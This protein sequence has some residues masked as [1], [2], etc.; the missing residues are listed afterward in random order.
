MFYN[1]LKN[2]ILLS[3]FVFLA[4][5]TVISA[6]EEEATSFKIKQQVTGLVA[7][8]IRPATDGEEWKNTVD[9]LLELGTYGQ[10]KLAG[11]LL[12]LYK[13]NDRLY[14]SSFERSSVN[15][16]F[17][18]LTFWWLSLTTFLFCK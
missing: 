8:L 2:R 3:L 9:E 5:I 12:G 4:Y 6:Q 17:N 16:S 1:N 13:K 15:F 14:L 18:S 7:Q 10:E 11:T